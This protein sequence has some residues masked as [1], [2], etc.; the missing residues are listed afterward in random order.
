MGL[1]DDI[2]RELQNALEEARR[3]T[4]AQAP[5][6]PAG[7]VARGRGAGQEGPAPEWPK[8]G[9]KIEQTGQSARASAA[10]QRVEGRLQRERLERP[11]PDAPA[12]PRRPS[13][14]D[15][16]RKVTAMEAGEPEA[17]GTLSSP[18][19]DLTE[20]ERA[21]VQTTVSTSGLTF[22]ARDV[23]RALVLGEVFDEPKGRR[24]RRSHPR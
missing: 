10:T 5:A 21:A 12:M 24:A 18:P 23:L 7:P 14:D 1:F 13:G 8:S 19:L 6:G 17:L 16:R 22:T 20:P 9:R 3:A 2:R 15:F 11:A 4:E